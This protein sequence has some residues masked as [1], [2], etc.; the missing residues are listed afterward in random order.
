MAKGRH[1]KYRKLEFWAER[2]LINIID[3][4]FPPSHAKAFTVVLV[5][6]FLLRL[7][8]LNTEVKRWGKKWP[9]E[10]DELVKMIED[11]VACCR[12]A[13]AQGR[14]DDPRACADILKERRRF[15]LYAGTSNADPTGA[16]ASS[17]A[18]ENVLLP[19]MPQADPNK[20]FT[21]LVPEPVSISKLFT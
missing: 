15:M 10:R 7:S 1:Y 5:R 6:E 20:P 17:D 16:L 8:H 12:D 4:R 19:P 14:P 13:K 11:G 3:E 2:G 21:P 9:D 18:P